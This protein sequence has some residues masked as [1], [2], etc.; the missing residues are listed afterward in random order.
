MS[1]LSLII[2]AI[3]LMTL[4]ACSQAGGS[5]ENQASASADQPPSPIVTGVEIR[6]SEVSEDEIEVWISGILPDT[7]SRIGGVTQE[8]DSENF[9][10]VLRAEAIDREGCDLDER[11]EFI[12]IVPI[13]TESLD[14]GLYF[15]W[16][17]DLG[18]SF[19]VNR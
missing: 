19:E 18:A 5:Q 10:L 2:F 3:A 7:C 15:V 11:A 8:Q 6:D 1:R 17:G 12:Q 4:L 13:P 16:A 14:A 9:R